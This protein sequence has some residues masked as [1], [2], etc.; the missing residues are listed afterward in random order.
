MAAMV[1]HGRPRLDGF[2]LSPLP[3][4]LEYTLHTRKIPHQSIDLLV[5]QPRRQGAHI[6]EV[7]RSHA[8]TWIGYTKAYNPGSKGIG[9]NRIVVTR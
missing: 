2:R 5:A 6:A 1:G 3:I 9:G 7:P 8:L 4:L